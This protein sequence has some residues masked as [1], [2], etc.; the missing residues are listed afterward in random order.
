MSTQT[1]P[2]NMDDEADDLILQIS[3]RMLNLFQRTSRMI[4]RARTIVRMTKVTWISFIFSSLLGYPFDKLVDYN[5]FVIILILT[6]I[7]ILART[8]L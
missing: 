7:C 5:V 8:R 2:Y 1:E 6:V 4:M 3:G